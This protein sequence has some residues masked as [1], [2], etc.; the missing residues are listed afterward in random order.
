MVDEYY[1]PNTGQGGYIVDNQS[2]DAVTSFG[3]ENNLLTTVFRDT[4][5]IRLGWDGNN[6][7]IL[8]RN[9]IDVSFGLIVRSAYSASLY[10]VTPSEQSPNTTKPRRV[11]RHREFY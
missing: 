5:S 10:N 11:M 2:T 4:N 7:S 3:V 8:W 9:G 1:D 6:E